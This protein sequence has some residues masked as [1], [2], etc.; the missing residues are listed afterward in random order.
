ML[1]KKSIVFYLSPNFS[2]EYTVPVVAFDSRSGNSFLLEM[3]LGTN[4]PD[5]ARERAFLVASCSIKVEELSDFRVRFFFA[6]PLKKSLS[7]PSS[8]KLGWTSV[9]NYTK[10]LTE[11]EKVFSVS[12]SRISR[13]FDEVRDLKGMREFPMIYFRANPGGGLKMRVTIGR[14][15]QFSRRR[16]QLGL[17]TKD[18]EEGIA[19]MS[20]LYTFLYLSG[21]C[22]ADRVRC[23]FERN[24]SAG[25]E[26]RSFELRCTLDGKSREMLS[27]PNKVY[28]FTQG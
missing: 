7:L 9:F 10:I 19:R 22:P 15:E 21:F 26:E 23:R 3:G 5:I 17:R 11:G 28:S 20:L 6:S 25:L 12:R 27:C 8:Q 1:K 13:L 2:G 16:V 24:E 14:G 18:R 4:S